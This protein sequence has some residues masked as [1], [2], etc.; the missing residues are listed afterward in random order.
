[1]SNVEKL[2]KAGF[3]EMP[4]RGLWFSRDRRMAF[5]DQAIEDMDPRWLDRYTSE[6]V[7]PDDFVF[8][9]VKPPKN[10]QECNQILAEIGLSQLHANIRLVTVIG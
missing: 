4:V 10:I 3:S 7:G 5:S 1:M 6:E 2:L 9:Y 8:H